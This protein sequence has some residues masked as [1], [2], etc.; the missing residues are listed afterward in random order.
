MD[1]VAEGADGDFAVVADAD[2]GAPA[3]DV[4]PPGAGRDRAEDGALLLAGL[5]PGGLRRGAEF[6]VDFVGVGVE[7]ELVQEAV[8]GF[9][10][11]EV[12]GGQ[13]G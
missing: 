4:R 9:E 7:Q 12:I 6:A 13:E 8:G 1:G 2:A 5:I 10:L 3:P 11:A